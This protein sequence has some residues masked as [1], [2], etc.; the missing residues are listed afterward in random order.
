MCVS[1]SV[2]VCVSVRE[3]EKLKEKVRVGGGG[4]VSMCVI[5]EKS[6]SFLNPHI[7]TRNRKSACWSGRSRSDHKNTIPH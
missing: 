2:Y 6:S 7:I 1:V 4:S 5:W 3:R